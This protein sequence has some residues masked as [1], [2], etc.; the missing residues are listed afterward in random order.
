M[1][2]LLRLRPITASAKPW[3]LVTW[4]IPPVGCSAATSRPLLTRYSN[5]APVTP[6]KGFRIRKISYQEPEDLAITEAKR[7]DTIPELEAL[8][9]KGEA[10]IRDAYHALKATKQR[11]EPLPL[12]ER[13][14]QAAQAGAGRILAFLWDKREEAPKMEVSADLVDT[15]CWFLHAQG[16]EGFFWRWF[17]LEQKKNLAIATTHY[18]TVAFSKA[19]WAGR[20][21]GSLI[22]V[23]IE[24]AS[25]GNLD[26]ALREYFAMIGRVKK[27]D[28]VAFPI[29]APTVV[30]ERALSRTDTP[31]CD[32]RLFD[33]F[34]RTRTLTSKPGLHR[35]DLIIA[36]LL[37][38]HPTLPNPGPLLTAA[39]R[40]HDSLESE[41]FRG[42]RQAARNSFGQNLLRASYLLRLQGENDDA[43]WLHS[44]VEQHHNEVWTQR[45]R[46]LKHFKRD[47][48]LH[49]LIPPPTP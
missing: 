42:R 16:L 5:V 25:D 47:P 37:L 35:R 13:W 4:N 30:L 14:K 33:R 28:P 18:E 20:L 7:V 41:G 2:A 3:R 11:L 21:L 26:S 15:V 48:K 44:V 39:R 24:W 34:V 8:I 22:S 17:E 27:I 9:A 45:T 46:I 32:A 29:V 38:Y 10:S 49:H 31:P 40:Y 6:A 36:Q 1:A 23:R 43:D 12:D 19:H